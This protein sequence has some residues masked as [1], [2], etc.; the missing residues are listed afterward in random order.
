MKARRLNA[1]NAA[2]LAG[3]GIDLLIQGQERDLL[4][5]IAR[6]PLFIRSLVSGISM[7]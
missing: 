4:A 1:P 6:T 3:A 7:R 5:P 2:L